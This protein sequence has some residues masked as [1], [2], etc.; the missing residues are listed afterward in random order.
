MGKNVVLFS[1]G[2]DSFIMY[3]WLL[4]KY[5]EDDIVPIYF[6]VKSKYSEKE[7]KVVL[8]RIPDTIIDDSLNLGSREAGEKAII[9]LRNM[10]FAIQAMHYGNTIWIAG[11]GDDR[12]DDKTEEAFY[13]MTEVLNRMTPDDSEQYQVLSPFWKDT[14]ADIVK[15]FLDTQVIGTRD[16]REKLLLL[17]TSCYDPEEHYCGKCPSCFR[18]WVALAV[19]GIHLSFY[20]MDLMKRYAE[21]ALNDHSKIHPKRR[22]DTLKA[23]CDYFL[24]EE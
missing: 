5:T 2:I 1:G 15:W 4:Q 3:H 12:A 8:N 18:K 24:G 10:L 9:P 20:N 17:T 11:T 13:L 14:K 19:N 23:I 6:D 16:Y 7:K 22:R 21:E